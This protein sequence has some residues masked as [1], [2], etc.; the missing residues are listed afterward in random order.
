MR[1]DDDYP[2]GKALLTALQLTAMALSVLIVVNM[3]IEA[4]TNVPHSMC[5]VAPSP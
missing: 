1:D 2:F 4:A 5:L 3:T